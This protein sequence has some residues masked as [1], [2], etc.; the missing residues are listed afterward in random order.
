[1]LPFFFSFFFYLALGFPKDL[2]EIGAVQRW[3]LISYADGMMVNGDI[4]YIIINL[5]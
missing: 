4:G 2:E 1:M 3:R 5:L